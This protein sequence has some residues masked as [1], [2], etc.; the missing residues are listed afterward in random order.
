MS[1]DLVRYERRGVAA[2][3]TLNR[4]D[5]RNALSRGLINALTAAINQARDDATARCLV[6]TGAGPVFC[7]GMDLA[8]LQESTEEKDRERSP[9]WEDALRLAQMYD[10]IYA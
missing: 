4:P 10:L 3:V 8:E 9:V 2:L 5:R 1:E 7:A 6:L